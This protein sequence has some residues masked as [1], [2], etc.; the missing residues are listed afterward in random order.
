MSSAPPGAATPA[1][2]DNA[3]DA[4]GR[5]ISPGR[6]AR[7]RAALLCSTGSGVVVVEAICRWLGE[8]AILRPREAVGLFEQHT[9]T[10]P[11]R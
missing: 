1:P 2:G 4:L 7:V 8:G 11:V 6:K 9:A 3:E 10:C 5:F